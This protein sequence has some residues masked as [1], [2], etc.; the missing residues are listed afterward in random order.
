MKTDILTIGTEYLTGMIKDEDSFYIAGR[1]AEL[2]AELVSLITVGDDPEV[3]GRTLRAAFESADMIIVTGACKYG[4]NPAF[5]QIFADCFG[6]KL[7]F[8]EPAFEHMKKTAADRKLHV[9][10]EEIRAL[11]EYPDSAQILFN[12]EGLACGCILAD[13]KK[14]LIV[15]PGNSREIRSVFEDDAVGYIYK[16]TSLGEDE[17]TIELKDQVQDN[18]TLYTEKELREKLG[19]LLA[20]DN[21]EL[22]LIRFGD[23]FQIRIHAVGPTV[24]DASILTFLTASDCCRRIGEDIIRGVKHPD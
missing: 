10:E 22:S 6:V 18:K 13:A 3:V 2:N 4:K 24:S 16:V 17:L 19:D 21:P 7:S 12:H 15:L 11:S 5:R 14:H 23:R 20:G 1:L 9:P 8:Q